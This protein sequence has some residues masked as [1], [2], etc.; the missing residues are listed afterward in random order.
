M[1][2]KDPQVTIWLRELKSLSMRCKTIENE[3]KPYQSKFSFSSII[4]TT[5]HNNN[6]KRKVGQ[7]KGTNSN[8][9]S[10]SN[11]LTYRDRLDSLKNKCIEIKKILVTSN[12]FLT[13][14]ET[15]GQV[16]NDKNAKMLLKYKTKFQ[17]KASLY[18]KDVHAFHDKLKEDWIILEKEFTT[19]DHTVEAFSEK[20]V[21]WEEVEARADEAIGYCSED[22]MEKDI[23]Q[24]CP[25][26]KRE[27]EMLNGCIDYTH[28][29]PEK[30]MVAKI[31]AEIAQDGGIFGNWKP[32]EH[33]AFL[34]LWSYFHGNYELMIS[35]IYPTSDNNTNSNDVIIPRNNHDNFM[36][37]SAQLKLKKKEDI[38]HHIDWYLRHNQRM[39]DKKKYV[40]DWKQKRK[41]E[42]T[43]KK[44]SQVNEHDNNDTSTP[45]SSSKV[46]QNQDQERIGRKKAQIMAWRRKKK[47]RED[48]KRIKEKQNNEKKIKAL[49]KKVSNIYI[50]VFYITR[51]RVFLT[52]FFSMLA[53][54]FM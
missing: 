43:Q 10:M 49:E 19:L 26:R 51:V 16:M 8:S 20:I 41:D 12:K 47:E 28:S 7:T 27:A 15:K 38:L 53:I 3:C 14:Q 50:D 23:D 9:T 31:D 24:V 39:I 13:R 1:K 11:K 18:K 45:S 5:A 52:G 33:A 46:Q 17:Q 40:A 29:C 4:T 44:E 25:T 30:Y 34:K 36:D 6:S 48:E 37:A 54:T 42:R 22:E 35:S 2:T 32:D 21:L